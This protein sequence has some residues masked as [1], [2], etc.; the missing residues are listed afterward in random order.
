MRKVAAHQKN[1]K[2][3]R[4][5]GKVVELIMNIQF[6]NLECCPYE[7]LKQCQKFGNLLDWKGSVPSLPISEIICLV[8]FEY[9]HNFK[10]ETN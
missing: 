6:A 5:K 2:K 7:W 9:A 3:I 1:N 4:I 10:V 8:F